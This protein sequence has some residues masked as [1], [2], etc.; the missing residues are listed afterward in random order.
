MRRSREKHKTKMARL[1]TDALQEEW[2]AKLLKS[3]VDL[4]IKKFKH[5]AKHLRLLKR[6]LECKQLKR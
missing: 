4:K 5:L 1:Q 2:R 3:E 6:K